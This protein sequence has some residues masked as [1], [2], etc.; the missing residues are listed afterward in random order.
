MVYFK[1]Y[2]ALGCGVPLTF[3]KCCSAGKCRQV[4]I[5]LSIPV[6]PHAM[7]VARAV[8]YAIFAPTFLVAIKHNTEQ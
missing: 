3:V 8:L 2:A 5:L 7:K 4:K 6:K 1:D